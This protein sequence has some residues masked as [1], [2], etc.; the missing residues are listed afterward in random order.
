MDLGESPLQF[1][2]TAVLEGAIRAYKANKAPDGKR[3]R[4]RRREARAADPEP[5]PQDKWTYEHQ[6]LGATVDLRASVAGGH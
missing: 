2:G 4:K 5:E 3:E 6:R 1:V